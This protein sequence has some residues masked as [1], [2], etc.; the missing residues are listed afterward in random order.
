MG[1]ISIYIY[2]VFM[3]VIKQVITGGHHH[4]LGFN[5][6]TMVNK[7]PLGE[8]KKPKKQDER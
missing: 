6:K 5:P 7:N 2:I 1:V 3:G 8:T 4:K